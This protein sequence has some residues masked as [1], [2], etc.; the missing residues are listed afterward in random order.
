M[1]QRFEVEEF[2]EKNNYL[3]VVK[4]TDTGILLIL[5]DGKFRHE[6]IPLNNLYEIHYRDEVADILLNTEEL[7][8]VPAYAARM[9]VAT[10]IVSTCEFMRYSPEYICV[11]NQE[12]LKVGHGIKFIDYMEYPENEEQVEKDLQFNEIFTLAWVDGFPIEYEIMA[13][14]LDMYEGYQEVRDILSEE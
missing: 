4:P 14:N 3:V 6:S 7:L 5:P 9:A 8:Q 10:H 1:V 12:D 2:L 13:K 11:K